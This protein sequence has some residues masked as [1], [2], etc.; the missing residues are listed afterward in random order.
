MLI[1]LIFSVVAVNQGLFPVSQSQLMSRRA[2]AGGSMAR[3]VARLA[4]GN[5]PRQRGHARFVTGL[6]WGAGGFWLFGFP[7]V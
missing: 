6:G 1:T 7:G 5:I 4:D 3:Q 2:G